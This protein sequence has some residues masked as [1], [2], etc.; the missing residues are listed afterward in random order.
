MFMNTV[1]VKKKKSK[2][3]HSVILDLKSVATNVTF[4]KAIFIL[5]KKTT[6]MFN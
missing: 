3:S 6:K 5:T 4:M 2:T 1:K